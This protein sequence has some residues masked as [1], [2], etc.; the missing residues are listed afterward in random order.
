MSR[1]DDALEDLDVE[2]WLEDYEEIR[3][4]GKYEIRLQNCPKCGNDDFKL[5]VNTEKLVWICYVCDYGRHQ[6]DICTLLADVAGKSKAAIQIELAQPLKPTPKP[7]EFLAKLHESFAAPPQGGPEPVETVILPG[8]LGFMGIVSRR[9]REY[10]MRRG[11]TDMD[12]D[13]YQLRTATKLR[14]FP[15]PYLV[16]P[17]YFEGK[18]VAWQG[19]TIGSA[20]PKYVSSDDV[21]NWLWPMPDSAERVTLVEG[22]FDA[23]ALLR[24]GYNACCTFGKK[25]SKR[26]LGHLHRNHVTEIAFAW[27]ANALTDIEREAR[28]AQ[29]LFPTVSIVDL[30]KPNDVNLTD[31]DPGDCLAHPQLKRWLHDCVGD[32]I[33]VDSAEFFEWCL[34]RSLVGTF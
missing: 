11:L 20:E 14:N 21:A 1:L 4:G 3:P 9:V 34:Q 19:R 10:A 5:Y 23:I 30:S 15:G 2:A 13:R 24:C 27:D 28:R 6:G 33:S 32:P 8:N 18:P 22:V 12:L 17:V 26:Q 16:F 29:G 25:I 7:S 31:P